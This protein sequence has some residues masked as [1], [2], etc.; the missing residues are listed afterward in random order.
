MS[1]INDGT[2]GI[3]FPDGSVQ[4][5]AASAGTSFPAGTKSLFVQTSAPTGWTKVTTYDNYALRIVSGTAG[6]GGSVAFTTAFASGS[7]GAYT[8]ATADIPSHKHSMQL[9]GGAGS[10]AAQFF[11]DTWG[12]ASSIFPNLDTANTGGGGSHSHSLSLAVQYVDTI[13]ATKN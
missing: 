10:P 1:I 11:A 13:I 5:T 6:T 12:G 7:T 4:T 9:A 8:L 2:S 3:T